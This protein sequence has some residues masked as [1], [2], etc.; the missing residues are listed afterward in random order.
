MHIT[1]YDGAG[2]SITANVDFDA[3]SNGMNNSLIN[4]LVWGGYIDD[5]LKKSSEKYLKAKNNLGVNLSYDV[6]AF[7][8]EGGEKIRFVDEL[9]NQE[10]LNATYPVI[11]TI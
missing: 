11:F 1:K 9:K 8:K 6:S 2:R 4:K 5:D 10:I 7:L 3:G